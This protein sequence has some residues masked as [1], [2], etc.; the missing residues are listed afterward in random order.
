[1]L[2]ST[3]SQPHIKACFSSAREAARIAATQAQLREIE[4]RSLDLGVADGLAHDLA[5]NAE[6]ID[7]AGR[8]L[9]IVESRTERLRGYID[10]MRAGTKPPIITQ[11]EAMAQ[12]ANAGRA[13]SLEVA[14]M[15]SLLA[16]LTERLADARARHAENIARRRDLA[17]RYAMLVLRSRSRAQASHRRPATHRSR[18]QR[19]S[20]RARTVAR[21]AAKT[22]S[23]GDPDPEPDSSARASSSGGAP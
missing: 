2:C 10:S 5:I 1:M 7:E 21:V 3:K 13:Q 18:I 14:E 17:A 9:R 19:C 12:E 15:E 4:I 22:S 11:I 6:S 23:T 8:A 16:K 20:R